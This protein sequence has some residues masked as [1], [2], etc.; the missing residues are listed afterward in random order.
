MIDPVNA[1]VNGVLD[2]KSYSDFINRSWML[3]TVGCGHSESAWRD[4]VSNLR[5]V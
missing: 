3:R 2:T 1:N 4:M 5:L